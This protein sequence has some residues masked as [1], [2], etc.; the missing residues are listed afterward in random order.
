MRVSLTII[1][2]VLGLFPTGSAQ[3]QTEED[4]T[5]LIQ[6][7]VELDSIDLTKYMKFRPGLEPSLYA[8]DADES[9][10]TVLKNPYEVQ[11]Q[12]KPGAAC[13]YRV[14][15]VVPKKIGKFPVPENMNFGVE[16]NVLGS[17]EAYTYLNGKPAGFGNGLMRATN[18]NPTAWLSAAPMRTQ[19]GDKLTVAILAHS[20]PL[21][22]GTPEGFGLRHLRLRFASGHTYGRGPF[23]GGV[24]GPGVGSGLLGARERLA[25]A[26]GEDL[27]VL[28]E[29]L[30]GPLS[31][32]DAVF[33]AAET[34]KLEE[35]TKAMA[36]A[37]KE[38]NEA[39]KK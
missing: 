28:Q 17:W 24:T 19:A 4:V 10:M 6:G 22:R 21:G 29:K 3:A 38:I 33:K 13:W 32:L 9:K 26:K 25:T 5:K 23:F 30:K 11:G 16:F 27:K 34:E 8:V 37:S 18:Q 35:L 20:T 7:L 12:G 15:L 2:L 14:N 31:R 1:L 39:L 36:T